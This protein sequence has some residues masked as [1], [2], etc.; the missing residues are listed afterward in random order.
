[1]GS[2]CPPLSVSAVLA[3]AVE[4]H[5]IQT[6]SRFWHPCGEHLFHD[7]EIK[8]WYVTCCVLGSLAG[9]IRRLFASPCGRSVAQ[10]SVRPSLMSAAAP[11]FSVAVAAFSEP[12]AFS[13]PTTFCIAGQSFIMPSVPVMRRPFANAYPCLSKRINTRMHLSVPWLCVQGRVL[14]RP[15]LPFISLQLL[16][17]PLCV[18]CGVL[19]CATAQRTSLE[20]KPLLSCRCAHAGVTGHGTLL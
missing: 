18:H 8:A 12:R 5:V 1:M 6:F 11:S 2:G 9:I 17:I 19:F 16:S 13:R 4:W 20:D 10:P 15:I 14:S 3:L 7:C